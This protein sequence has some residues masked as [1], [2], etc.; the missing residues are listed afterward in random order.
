M[1]SMMPL[2]SW[3][4]FAADSGFYL[5]D[6]IGRFFDTRSGKGADVQSK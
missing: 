3:P 2:S 6:Q 1:L 4:G 5:I